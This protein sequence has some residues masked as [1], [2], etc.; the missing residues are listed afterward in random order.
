VDRADGG[1]VPGSWG[2]CAAP[3]GRDV[4]VSGLAA[5]V[6]RGLGVE[7]EAQKKEGEGG[8]KGD[9]EESSESAKHRRLLL[10]FIPTK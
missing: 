8:D 3:G 6:V 10:T 9:E 7:A 5:G 1:R 4:P 2:P